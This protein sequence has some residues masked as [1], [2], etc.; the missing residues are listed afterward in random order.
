LPTQNIF[1]SGQVFYPGIKVQITA[2]LAACRYVDGEAVVGFLKCDNISLFEAAAT[3][4]SHLLIHG[5]RV[6]GVDSLM[7]F[8]YW[9]L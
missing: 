7:N 6:A 1:L 8:G 5:T 2:E 4:A 9:L 3:D